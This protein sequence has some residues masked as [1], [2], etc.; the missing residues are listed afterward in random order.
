MVESQVFIE[1]HATIKTKLPTP[2]FV[3]SLA[4]GL[5]KKLEAFQIVYEQYLKKGLI[6][7]NDIMMYIT[8]KDLSGGVYTLTGSLMGEVVSTLSIN[9]RIDQNEFGSDT[10]E[11]IKLA[12]K[13]RYKNNL[14]SLKKLM[15]LSILYSRYILKKKKAIIE[16]H[17]KHTAFYSRFM[18]FRNCGEEYS[19][20]RVKGA[21]AIFMKLDLVDVELNPDKYKSYA[22]GSKAQDLLRPFQQKPKL[23]KSER[24]IIS[25]IFNQ[26][27]GEK[28]A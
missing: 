10:I 11:I 23:K 18:G 8:S 13:D 12:V 26:I 17:P 28:I 6:E 3:F 24:M 19:C 2:P 1:D 15:E 20:K 21:S 14:K 25:T 27:E 7:S 16:V 9:T 4:T 5:T 22:S